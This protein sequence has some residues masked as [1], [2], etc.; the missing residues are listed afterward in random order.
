MIC[1]G[2]SGLKICFHFSTSCFILHT[3]ITALTT[4]LNL[5][6]CSHQFRELEKRQKQTLLLFNLDVRDL[7]TSN[8]SSI[9]E[10]S[11]MYVIFFGDDFK[12]CML[13]NDW[14]E[15]KVRSTDSFE[16]PK[17]FKTPVNRVPILPNG[18]YNNLLSRQG[19]G[20]HKNNLGMDLVSWIRNHGKKVHA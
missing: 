16:P 9:V 8:P 11:N 13:Q 2:M 18:P 4:L 7:K 20:T 14:M 17:R 10:G 3:D 12:R 5:S 6:K 15:S 19:V 1:L